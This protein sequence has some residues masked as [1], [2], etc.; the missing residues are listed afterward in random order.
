MSELRPPIE[1]KTV[2]LAR[3]LVGHT[4]T[5]Y[6]IQPGYWH[7]MVRLRS[8]ESLELEFVAEEHRLAHLFDVSCIT[9]I[10]G[11]DHD[12]LWASLKSPLLVES[13]DALY[14][15]EWLTVGAVGPTIG[16]DPHTQ[17]IG[18][19]GSAPTT[20]VATA[21]VMSGLLFKGQGQSIAVVV[22]AAAPLNVD[23]FLDKDGLDELVAEHSIVILD[24]I[25]DE[26]KKSRAPTV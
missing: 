9:C 5:D 21:A 17:H 24:T 4:I 8:V 6:S 25:G 14:R 15:D 3:A 12:A 11:P 1:S 23:I 18:P 22:S 26:V 10:E 19:L 7:G 13:I 16:N 20:S 2:T